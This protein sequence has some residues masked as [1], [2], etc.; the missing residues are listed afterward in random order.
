MK[1][2]EGAVFLRVHLGEGEESSAEFPCFHPLIGSS[3]LSQ[4]ELSCLVGSAT[5]VLL[6]DWSLRLLELH[7]V[8]F[9]EWSNIRIL[10]SLAHPEDLSLHVKSK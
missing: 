2:Q 1:N 9:P 10:S 8:A 7:S 3:D 6:F 5:Y 4:F